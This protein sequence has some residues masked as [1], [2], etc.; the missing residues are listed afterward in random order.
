MLLNPLAGI[1][2]PDQ[3]DLILILIIT[4]PL[5]YL[6]S[7]I[8]N[9]FLFLALTMSLTISFQSILFP[10]DRWVLWTQQQV[11][12]LLVIFSPRKHVGKIVLIESFLVLICLHLRRLFMFYGDNPFDIT[13]IFMM[14]MFNYIGL[15]FNYQNGA[16]AESDLS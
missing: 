7:L 6:L 3:A 11:I 15:A 4:I 14:Q 13:G 8:Y 2:P 12:F 10:N 1:L 16:K 5:S 9:K